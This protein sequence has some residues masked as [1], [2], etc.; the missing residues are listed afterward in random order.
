MSCMSWMCVMC[1]CRLKDYIIGPVLNHFRDI[2]NIYNFNFHK[3]KL[4]N[5]PQAGF[6]PPLDRDQNI[7][8]EKLALKRTKPPWLDIHLNLQLSKGIQI[9]VSEQVLYQTDIIDIGWDCFNWPTMS[10][11]DKIKFQLPKFSC[12]V[13]NKWIIIFYSAEENIE[14]FVKVWWHQMAFI[15]HANP[16]KLLL[17][18]IGQP[19]TLD[20]EVIVK[21]ILLNCFK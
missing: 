12:L 10:W 1:V 8:N 4:N 13:H 17:Y 2:Y 9:T 20:K 14:L 11:N 7:L 6:D 15:M 16:A 3:L 19:Y 5:C 21:R 18:V